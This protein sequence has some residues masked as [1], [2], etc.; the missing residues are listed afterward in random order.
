MT[1]DFNVGWVEFTQDEAQALNQ[2]AQAV[3]ILWELHAP[4]ARAELVEGR[5][6]AVRILHGA[7]NYISANIGEANPANP[8]LPTKKVE[9]FRIDLF[10][11]S[12]LDSGRSVVEVIYET[13]P[14]PV[15]LSS[16]AVH[17]Y[18]DVDEVLQSLLAHVSY[19][20]RKQYPVLAF[21]FR[22]RK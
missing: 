5:A 17:A 4:P 13:L 20:L 12:R 19:V 16:E 18:A 8:Y 7:A 10:T 11:P 3:N 1:I 21:K 2:A 14:R 22:N 6:K 9:D 15:R